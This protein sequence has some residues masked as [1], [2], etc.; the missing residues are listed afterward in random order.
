MRH[1]SN[2]TCFHKL[3]GFD[4]GAIS[5]VLL[6]FNYFVTALA[7]LV[8]CYHWQHLPAKIILFK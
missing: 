6:H 5:W 3:L 7:I 1:F 2:N 8:I 4:P